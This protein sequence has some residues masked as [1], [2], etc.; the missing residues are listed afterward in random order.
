MR[1]SRILLHGERLLMISVQ[2]DSASV[3]TMG[4]KE[5]LALELPDY[6]NKIKAKKFVSEIKDKK[7]V[8]DLKRF[9]NKRSLD[10]NA[11]F[12]VLVGKIAENQ[13]LAND[14]VKKQLVLDYGTL[15]VDD[16]ENTIGF[17][18][19]ETV[20]PDMLYPY[21][22]QFDER[23]EN[24]KLF[25]CYL[26]YKR[27]RTLDSKEMARLI[28]GTVYEAKNLGIETLSPAEIERMNAAWG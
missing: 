1:R 16:E 17:K 21:T 14:E 19:P 12:H 25:I 26:V 15:A 7:Y 4:D 11:Y 5:Y 18:L 8:A 27:T 23:M 28:E 22:K 10:S 6:S 2:F 9:F 20:D 3:M 13:G 24:G